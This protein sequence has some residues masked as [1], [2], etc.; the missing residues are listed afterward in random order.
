[1]RKN[2]FKGFTLIEGLYGL[3]VTA[4]VLSFFHPFIHYLSFYQEQH[5]NQ[6]MMEWQTFTSQLERAVTEGTI[7][8]ITPQ[9]IEY[10]D[11]SGTHYCVEH[12][13]NMIRRTT[14]LSG[15]E[16]L[17]LNVSSWQVSQVNEQQLFITVS[18][19][20]G[21]VR[22]HYQTFNLSGEIENEI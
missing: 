8:T 6:A 1:M 3:F 22:S 19:L 10:N 20:D 7:N 12:Y 16:P 9:T 5:S 4:I 21:S 17:L 13:Q 11:A 14:S 2:K 18:F 15:H